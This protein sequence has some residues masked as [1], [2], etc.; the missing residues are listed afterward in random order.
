MKLAY[1]KKRSRLKRY[2]LP[3]VLVLIT[4]SFVIL[5]PKTYF[6]LFHGQTTAFL[7][8]TFI[9]TLSS[10]YGGF[11]PGIFA[12]VIT[13]AL[14]YYVI[15][16]AD[17]SYQPLQGDLLLTFIYL[18][19]GIVISILSEARYEADLKKDEFIGIAAHELKTPLSTIKG[20]AELLAKASRKLSQKKIISYASEIELQSDRLLSLVEGLLNVTKIEIGKF[21]Y[22]DEP[23]DLNDLVREVI[24][25][26]KLIEK[27]RKITLVGKCKKIICGD[28]YRIG[29]VITNLLTNAIKYSPPK[30]KIEIRIKEK[31][32]SVFLSIKD[33]GIGIPKSDQKHIFSQY[34]QAKK[35]HDGTTEGLGMG[36]YISS[37]II[38]NYHGK[39]WVKNNRGKGST[40]FL[41][42][43]NSNSRSWT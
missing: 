13:A 36:L 8:L 23:F 30:S 31:G 4:F 18:L 1:V 19:E 40:F 26:Q 14:N 28:R 33:Y 6:H 11:G 2:G 38:K 7:T 15:L 42:L 43:P 22:K 5:S 3:L 34:Y 35:A 21:E 25:Y 10:W 32:K 12:T 20:F 39:L 16:R 24:S 9:V 27:N 37:Q 29:Q 41:E 17:P